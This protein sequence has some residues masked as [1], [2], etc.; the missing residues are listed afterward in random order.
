MLH[1]NIVCEFERETDDLP[2]F[3]GRTEP[4]HCI[5]CMRRFAANN[6]ELINQHSRRYGA[7]S[8]APQLLKAAME[9]GSADQSPTTW[10]YHLNGAQAF[11]VK[12][13]PFFLGVGHSISEPWKQ[14][15]RM[16]HYQRLRGYVRYFYKMEM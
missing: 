6:T 14:V 2:A 9:R 8:L 7:A 11:K 4:D 1:P 16:Q 3:F 13:E 5:L 10:H 15:E 12:G